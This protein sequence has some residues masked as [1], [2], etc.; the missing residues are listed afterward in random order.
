MHMA[1]MH[2]NGLSCLHTFNLRMISA[3]SATS[4]FMASDYPPMRGSLCGTE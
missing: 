2:S 1:R 3:L 4:V